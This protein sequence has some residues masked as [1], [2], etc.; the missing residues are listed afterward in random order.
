M[1]RRSK[2][3]KQILEMVDTTKTYGLDEAIEILKKVPAA[4]FDESIDLSFKLTVDPK[5]ADQ[6][7]RGTVSLPHGTGKKVVLVV[8]AKG[9]KIQEALDAGADY[10]GGEELIERVKNGWTD[11]TAVMSTPEMMR[12]VGKLGKVLGPRGLMPSPKAGTVTNDVAKGVNEIKAGKVEFKVDKS[13]VINNQF[14]KVSFSKEQIIEN[15]QSI[16]QAIVRARPSSAKGSY[17]KSLVVSTTMGP[18]LSI[19]TQSYV[20]A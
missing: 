9:N 4:K 15:A 19:A 6:Q 18:G 5:K 3:Y 13:S 8:F 10:A 2:R 7:V 1:V 11:F 14:A 16:I 20:N 12:E 17:I